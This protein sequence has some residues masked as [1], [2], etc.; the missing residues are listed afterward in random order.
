MQ[1][2]T[3]AHFASA[4]RYTTRVVE[5]CVVKKA[6]K[7]RI[8]LVSGSTPFEPDQIDYAKAIQAQQDEGEH[9]TANSGD[10][11]ILTS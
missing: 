8:G 10:T 9:A 5:T 11:Y 6:R 7:V 2:S 3:A 4:S 1:Y